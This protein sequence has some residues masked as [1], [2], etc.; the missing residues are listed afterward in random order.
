MKQNCGMLVHAVLEWNVAPVYWTDRGAK[1][2][3]EMGMTIVMDIE[4]MTRQ[5]ENSVHCACSVSPCV[6]KGRQ[7]WLGHCQIA[8]CANTCNSIKRRN[9]S[10]KVL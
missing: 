2:T 4:I 8:T 6:T 9:T 10:Q 7:P 5:L 1:N 3:A